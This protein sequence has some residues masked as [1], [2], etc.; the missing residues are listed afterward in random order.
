[1]VVGGVPDGVPGAVDYDELVA[2]SSGP[3]PARGDED[4]VAWQ[5]Y[6]SG[7]TSNPKGCLL[8]HE[9]M[10]RSS[11]VLGK[12][13]FRLSHQDKVWSPL[14]L[15]HIAAMLPLVAAF[16]VGA[17]YLGMQHFEPGLS[18]DMIDR[19]GVTMI[20]APFV[21]FLQPM[22]LHPKFDSTDFSKVR[23]MNIKVL[24]I[25]VDGVIVVHPHSQG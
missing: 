20:F 7:T 14:P 1:M 13:R 21:T 3:V 25:D 11:I 18:L 19:N 8:S 16:S 2:S 5:L 24:M 15:F 12:H 6:T 22:A 9:A 10:A 17:T 23:L 4:E